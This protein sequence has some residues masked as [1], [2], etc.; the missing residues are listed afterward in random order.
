MA[1]LIGHLFVIPGTDIQVKLFDD[2]LVVESPGNLHGLVRP[3]NIRHTHFSRNPRLARYLKTYKYV[4]EFGE[5]VDRMC[6]EME[7][8]GLLP[9]KYYKNDF[10]LRAVAWSKNAKDAGSDK[11]AISG[12]KVLIKWSEVKGRC[13]PNTIKILEYLA[14]NESISNSVAREITGLSASGVRRI[15]N[16]LIEN[17]IVTPEGDKKSCVYHLM[18]EFIFD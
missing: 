8:D 10:I 14:H 4:K 3:D 11:V 18:V 2:R 17:K 13:L 6:R 12:D 15:L 5:G 1:D 7:A 9:I 16:N